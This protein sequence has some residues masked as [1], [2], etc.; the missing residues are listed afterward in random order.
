[1]RLAL[2]LHVE[3]A[4]E[5]GKQRRLNALPFAGRHALDDGGLDA[6]R[7]PHSG[8]HIADRQADAHRSALLRAGYAHEAG[9]A[10]RDLIDAGPI[11]V[12]SIAAKAG[13]VRVDQTRVRL[14]ERVIAEA[15]VLHGAGLEVLDEDVGL[16]R[17]LRDQ[18]DAFRLAEVEHKTALVAMDAQVIDADAV[19]ERPPGANHL[20]LGR[21]L[22]LHHVG[23]EVREDHGA[24]RTGKRAR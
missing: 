20:T 7:R 18:S 3:H 5:A 4:N 22:D 16:G 23:A 9:H 15:H 21:R 13:D 12:R 8:A 2:A 11:S 6:E 10:L 1:M 19:G 17:Q 24:V 14:F